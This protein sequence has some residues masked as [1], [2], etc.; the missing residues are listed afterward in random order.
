MIQHHQKSA[1]FPELT[2]GKTATVAALIWT[3]TITASTFGYYV[4]NTAGFQ[5][6]LAVQHMMHEVYL[7]F[8]N[9]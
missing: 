3:L 9:H 2:I 7:F 1:T 6:V 8:R 4:R 5:V